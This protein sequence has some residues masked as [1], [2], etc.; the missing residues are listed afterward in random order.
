MQWQETQSSI[1]M[2]NWLFVSPIILCSTN[3][4]LCK[5]SIIYI[6]IHIFYIFTYI[7][8]IYLHIY[9]LYIY[10]YIL[11]IF[12]Y[13]MFY[14]YYKLYIEIYWYTS[15]RKFLHKHLRSLVDDCH[16]SFALLNSPTTLLTS[17]SSFFIHIFICR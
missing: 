17:S 13:N 8:S 16:I 10:I 4:A 1:P 15:T 5:D 2:K 3:R 6:C 11:Y 7:Y 12:I 14:K 9:I